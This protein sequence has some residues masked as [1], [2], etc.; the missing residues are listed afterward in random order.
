LHSKVACDGKI[1]TIG[2]IIGDLGTGNGVISQFGIGQYGT[3][4][5]LVILY[6][7]NSH[8]FSPVKDYL[9]YLYRP[10]FL[11]VTTGI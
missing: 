4:S 6:S 1:A 2:K 7:C 9:G 5:D 10:E 11:A 3:I 8:A